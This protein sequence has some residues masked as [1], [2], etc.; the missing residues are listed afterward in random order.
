MYLLVK[1][2]AIFSQFVTFSGTAGSSFESEDYE[3]WDSVAEEVLDGPQIAATEVS[4]Q[5]NLAKE[6]EVGMLKYQ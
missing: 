4:E 5:S 1:Q 6:S 3:A 2:W